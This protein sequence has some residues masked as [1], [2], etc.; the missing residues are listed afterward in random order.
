MGK[1][2]QGKYK[3]K[4]EIIQIGQFI[5]TRRFIFEIDEM[6]RFKSHW[7]IFLGL[8]TYINGQ[9]FNFNNGRDYGQI[10]TFGQRWQGTASE[11]SWQKR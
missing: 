10:A 5:N 7:T 9:S 6:L 1:K 8:A 2:L 11:I 4:N 3:K